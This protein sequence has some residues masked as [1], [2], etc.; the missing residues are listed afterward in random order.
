MHTQ[1]NKYNTHSNR[2]ATGM[3]TQLPHAQSGPVRFRYPSVASS[4]SVSGHGR[5]SVGQT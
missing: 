1:C 2:I 3:L 5:L 4:L